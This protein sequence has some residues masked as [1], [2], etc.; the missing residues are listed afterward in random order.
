LYG[1]SWPKELL[2]KRNFFLAAGSERKYDAIDPAQ[3][4]CNALSHPGD[5]NK[6]VARV[7][8]PDSVAIHKGRINNAIFSLCRPQNYFVG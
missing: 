2:R 4:I 1:A 3:K 6:G 5:K 7:G 8:H